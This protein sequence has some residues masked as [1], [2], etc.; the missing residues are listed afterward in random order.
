MKICCVQEKRCLFQER[1]C[2]ILR[3]HEIS[4]LNTIN[5]SDFIPQVFC[6]SNSFPNAHL[7]TCLCALNHYAPNCAHFSRTYEPI[8]SQD[9]RTDKYSAHMKSGENQYFN[10]SGVVSQDL[11]DK[12]LKYQK[13]STVLD[14]LMGSQIYVSAHVPVEIKTHK[15]GLNSFRRSLFQG[16]EWKGQIIERKTAIREIEVSLNTFCEWFQARKHMKNDCM[17]AQNNFRHKGKQVQKINMG[18]SARSNLRHEVD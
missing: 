13:E 17:M 3:V 10:I 1:E 4:F 9:H 14:F 7:P 16:F 11:L 12:N 2:Y 18:K 6:L 5:S 8:T 15:V